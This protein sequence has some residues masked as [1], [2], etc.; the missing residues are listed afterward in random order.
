MCIEKNTAK[1]SVLHDVPTYWQK[2]RKKERMKERKKKQVWQK[3]RK[4]ERK[5]ERRQKGA[6]DALTWL[7]DLGLTSLSTIFQSYRDGVWVW[8]RAQCYWCN[9]CTKRSFVQNRTLSVLLVR[10]QVRS[11]SI[12]IMFYVHWKTLRNDLYSKIIFVFVFI[13]KQ[14]F[15]FKRLLLHESSWATFSR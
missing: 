13:K 14:E 10:Y 12:F 1:R 2:E 6:A 4:K 5:K 11:I 3:E 8:Q 7:I 15:S 9:C